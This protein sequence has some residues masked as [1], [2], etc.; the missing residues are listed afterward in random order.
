MVVWQLPMA[1]HEGPVLFCWTST[2]LAV[3]ALL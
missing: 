2:H 1:E 3:Q